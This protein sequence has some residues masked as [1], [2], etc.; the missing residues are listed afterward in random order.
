[1][2]ELCRHYS[3]VNIQANYAN[4]LFHPGIEFL[5]SLGAVIVVGIGGYMSMNAQMP[6]ADVVGF[7][8][9]LSIFYQPLAVLSRLFEDVQV[10]YAGAVRIFE[11]LE[12]ESDVIEKADAVT[13]EK[14]EGKI[15]FENVSFKYIEEE[16][17]LSDIS[18]TANPGE[19]I[20]VVGPTGV[21]KTTIVSLIERFYDPQ[22]GRIKIDDT[23]IKD[24]A[25]DSLRS[26]ISIVLQDVFLFNGTIA[27]NIAY[28][29]KDADSAQIE[30]AA[31]IACADEFIRQ[32][33]QAYDT[34]IGER[35][36]R[37]SGGQK[38]RLSIARAVLRNTPIL[39]LDEATS[40]VDMETELQIQRAIENLTGSRTIIVIAHR[41]S[42]IISADQIIVL[43]KGAIIEKG[44]YEELMARDGIFARLNR[45]KHAAA[46]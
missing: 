29:V 6:V 26:Q 20:A 36:V 17:V 19:M 25:I 18:F 30:E 39:I 24:L 40:S 21:G 12:T 4:A 8:M 10:S 31:R 13:M 23:D 44:N 46:H 42:T 34:L 16:S 33:P 27:E 43:D 1:M 5:T 38:Q 14:C 28:G 11:I 35:G 37:L 45:S 22:G 15:A 41:L 7:I 2:R 32:M 3:H 9:Y